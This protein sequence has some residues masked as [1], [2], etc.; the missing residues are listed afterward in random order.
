[1]RTASTFSILFW[2]YHN[3]SAAGQANI[4]LR[5]TLNQRRVNISLKRKIDINLWNPTSQRLDC[6]SEM[7]QKINLDLNHIRSEVHRIY[8]QLRFEKRPFT[9]Q[10]IK[11]IYLGENS[12]HKS[13][14]DLIQYFN[15][16][17]GHTL[18]PNI[19]KQYQTSQRYMQDFI[20]KR[21]RKKD[22]YLSDLDFGFI[23]GFEKFLKGFSPKQGQQSMG[24][25]T[26]MKHIKRLKRLITLAYRIE[27]IERDPFLNYRV[28][29]K[30]TEREFL[31][32]LELAAIEEL[33]FSIR[34]LKIVRDLFIFSCYTGI[35]YGDIVQLS[36]SNLVLGIDGALWI[37]SKRIKT[38]V[39][40]K[41]PILPRAGSIIN[42]YQ[43]SMS[44]SACDQLLPRLSNQKLNSYL[45]EIADRAG[46]RKNLTFHMARHTF[47]TT[48]TL[49]NGVP[50][51]TV[52]KMLGHTKLATT[53]IYSRVVEKKISDDMGK[54]DQL[55]R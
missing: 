53:Q 11:N 33:S 31:T 21:F 20:H 23:L 34:R 40:F 13:F 52:S 16:N 8:D 24:H 47:A 3:R 29:I 44:D 39:T 14:D 49:S 2:I 46:I 22:I 32:D 1:M 41:I 15:E 17:L 10:E 26:A 37:S 45:K 43:D 12:K 27:W 4:Y 55:L 18:R 54:L 36:K 9:V 50:I 19:L 38:G 28:R 5:I 51:E 48:I 25:N 7:A 30:K 35:S 42:E 6:T